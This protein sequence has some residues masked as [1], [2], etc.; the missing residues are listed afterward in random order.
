MA[1]YTELRFHGIRMFSE[2]TVSTARTGT[3]RPVLREVQGELGFP[4][5]PGSM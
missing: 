4:S 1:V 5:L 2:R 3:G